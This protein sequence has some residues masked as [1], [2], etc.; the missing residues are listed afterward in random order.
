[1]DMLTEPKKDGSFL[2][3]NYLLERSLLK[4][5]MLHRLP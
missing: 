4:S 1:M 5:Q 2:E 3:G